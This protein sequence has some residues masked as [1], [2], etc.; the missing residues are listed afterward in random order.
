MTARKRHNCPRQLPRTRGFSRGY[1]L[2]SSALRSPGVVQPDRSPQERPR[3]PHPDRRRTRRAPDRRSSPRPPARR[4]HHRITGS[5]DHR[6]TLPNLKELR[7]G[8]K[9]DSEVRMLFVFNP[10][11]NAVILVGGNKAG[12]WSGWYRTAIKEAEAAYQ[13]YTEEE[14]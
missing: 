8:S 14:A 5:P 1:A 2:A 3:H 10:E 4:P 7:P 6:I 9:G 11:R 12:N 13:A